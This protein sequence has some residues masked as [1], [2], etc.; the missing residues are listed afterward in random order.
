[1]IP[2]TEKNLFFVVPKNVIDTNNNLRDRVG[3]H[4]MTIN[5]AEENNHHLAIL[6]LHMTA[7][8]ITNS[9]VSNLAKVTEENPQNI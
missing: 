7:A 2:I 4:Q 9:R 6:N 8:V 1:M 3:Q 5:R